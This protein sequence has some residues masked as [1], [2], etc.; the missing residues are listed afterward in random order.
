MC[1]GCEVWMMALPELRELRRGSCRRCR[2][3]CRRFA[4]RGIRIS[5]N[6]FAVWITPLKVL[7]LLHASTFCDRCAEHAA[8]D[9]WP[10]IQH[11]AYSARRGERHT[12]CHQS[13]RHAVRL[14]QDMV[15]RSQALFRAC[16]SMSTIAHWKPV[17]LPG[18]RPLRSRCRLPARDHSRRGSFHHDMTCRFEPSGRS[19]WFADNRREMRTLYL[20]SGRHRRARAARDR[21]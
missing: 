21:A 13:D 20:A 3:L 9:P 15:F 7:P 17:A 19:R 1:S 2:T 18:S 11:V 12:L 14:D 10:W 8:G 16:R 5:L 4:P 6:E